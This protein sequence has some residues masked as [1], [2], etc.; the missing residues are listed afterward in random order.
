MC[1]YLN[2][3][4]MDPYTIFDFCH[5]PVVPNNPSPIPHFRPNKSYIAFIKSF[6]VNPGKYTIHLYVGRITQCSMK[7]LSRPSICRTILQYSISSL[8]WCSHNEVTLLYSQ[9][10]QAWTTYVPFSLTGAHKNSVHGYFHKWHLS[11]LQVHLNNHKSQL[12]LSYNIFR[13]FMYNYEQNIS[14]DQRK[15]KMV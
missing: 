5:L 10:G 9:P 12:L 15:C 8:Q 13:S 4:W 7:L 3:L 6:R 2:R 11:A 14:Y 1:N